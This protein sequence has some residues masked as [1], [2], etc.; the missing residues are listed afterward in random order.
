MACKKDQ[1]P[2]PTP[3]DP[4]PVNVIGYWEG[5][6]VDVAKGNKQGYFGFLLRTDST[7]LIYVEE[8]GITVADTASV[9]SKTEAKGKFKHVADSKT[10]TFTY[11]TKDY[12]NIDL[13]TS[14]VVSA[15]VKGVTGT[16]GES[17]SAND[18]GTYTVTKK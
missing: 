14:G 17:P 8:P 16:W 13:S 6:Y 2:E 15:D 11:S 12:P 5:K 9:S 7:A 18:R 1:K 4:Q 3:P 10:L